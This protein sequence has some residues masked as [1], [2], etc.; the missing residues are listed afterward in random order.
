MKD[1]LENILLNI[2][3]LGLKIKFQYKTEE[4]LLNI[5]SKITTEKENL[6][7]KYNLTFEADKNSIYIKRNNKVIR[8]FENYITNLTKE[9]KAKKDFKQ[10]IEIKSNKKEYYKIGFIST[11][12]EGF[13]YQDNIK[14][15]N[16]IIKKYL[17]NYYYD[18]I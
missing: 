12:Y 3:K 16:Q 4:E 13:I 6:L 10:I 11:K 2:D 7:E 15:S 9:E 18:F 14:K 5:L 1:E 8:I 17:E